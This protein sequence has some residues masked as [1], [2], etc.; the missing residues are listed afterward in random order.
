MK[1]RERSAPP[2]ILNLL[3]ANRRH[4]LFGPFGT[5]KTMFCAYAASVV[6]KR[7]GNVLWVS[8]DGGPLSDLLERFESFGVTEDQLTNQFH[9][10]ENTGQLTTQYS[11]W[12]RACASAHEY[13]LV[14]VDSSMG[15][16]NAENLDPNSAIDVDRWWNEVGD[17]FK[18]TCA[19]VVLIDH[20]GKSEETRRTS[21]GSHRKQ[22]A[23][24]V[25]LRLA[26]I[27]NLYR[28]T[29]GADVTGETRIFMEKDRPAFHRVKRGTQLGVIRFTSHCVHDTELHDDGT[30]KTL[31]RW[32]LDAT[33]AWGSGDTVSATTGRKRLT[34]YMERVTT[35]LQQHGGPATKSVIV[36]GVGGKKGCILRAIGTLA[37]EGYVTVQT[38]SSAHLVTLVR[39]Y[40]QAEDPLAQQDQADH[41]SEGS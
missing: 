8:I 26:E 11:K 20:S 25:V 23:P 19:A 13:E 34:W 28:A 38:S 27:S 35:F 37:E 39:A 32:T 10:L 5:A 16:M 1:G 30:V 4:L 3:Y 24:D 41:H 2:S 17:A 22:D 15:S 21:S 36:L 40:L 18:G 9:C 29:V 12:I 31:G 14:V 33:I 6:F 7:G